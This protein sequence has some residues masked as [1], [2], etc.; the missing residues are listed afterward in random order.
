MSGDA[1]EKEECEG[2][3][4]LQQQCNSIVVWWNVNNTQRLFS[5]SLEGVVCRFVYTTFARWYDST[6]VCT[7]CH[8]LQYYCTACVGLDICR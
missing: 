8:M 5:N 4:T 1:A 6:T 7:P 3:T 2:N